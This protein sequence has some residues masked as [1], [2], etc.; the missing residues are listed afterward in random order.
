MASELTKR[1]TTETTVNASPVEVAKTIK[2]TFSIMGIFY[3][4]QNS[5]EKADWIELYG[6]HREFTL[7]SWG[8]KVKIEIVG[9]G[10]GGSVVR[11]ES[12]AWLPTTIF[13]YGQ[14]KDNLKKIFTV[15]ITK[16]GKTSPLVIREKTF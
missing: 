10:I 6:E 2:G 14:N 15:L 9:D 8:E 1:A 16:Y 13:D 11:A 7:R 5:D 3:K 12:T 4:Q